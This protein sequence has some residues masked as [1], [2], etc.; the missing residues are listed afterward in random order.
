MLGGEEAALQ[1]HS[2][3]GID[4][5]L[6][7]LL[8]VDPLTKQGRSSLCCRGQQGRPAPEW[9]T[10]S[11]WGDL[12]DPVESLVMDLI[13]DVIDDDA[14][15]DGGICNGTR[16]KLQNV[17]RIVNQLMV[18]QNSGHE[19]NYPC[20]VLSSWLMCHLTDLLE[21]SAATNPVIYNN[22]I[23]ED[24]VCLLERYTPACSCPLLPNAVVHFCTMQLSTDV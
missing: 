4:L 6:G 19:R 16:K 5:M 22:V 24:A 15:S 8:F 20:A 17:G 18:A 1:K 10:S 21:Q 9:W 2:R 12:E 11:V 7:R 23:H 13:W 3:H 14:D